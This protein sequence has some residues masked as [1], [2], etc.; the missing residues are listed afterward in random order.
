[1]PKLITSPALL[2]RGLALTLLLVLALPAGAFAHAG[3]VESQPVPGSEL[4]AGPAQ[5]SLEFTEPLNRALTEVQLRDAEDG[6]TVPAAVSFPGESEVRLIPRVRL[7]RAA[8]RIEWRTVSTVDGHALEGSFGFGVGTPAP[9]GEGSV[10]QSPLARDG[11]LRIAARAVFYAALLFF[12]G[13]LFA[14]ILLGSPLE[15]ARWLF[16]PAVAAGLSAA[17]R[18]RGHLVEAAW[19]R[20]VDAGW[21]AAGA[22]ALVATV[23]AIDA[24]GGFSLDGMREFLLTN[25]AG[26]GR[27]AMV[28][29]VALA[30]AMAPRLRVGAFLSLIVAF[31]AIAISGHA[32]SAEL[33]GPA[34]LT[35]WI[36]LLAAAVWV[37][38]IAQIAWAWLPLVRRVGQDARREAIRRVL[39]RFGRLALPAFAVVVLSGL[40]NALIELGGPEAL[41]ETSYGRVLAVKIALVG[42]IAAASYGHALRLRPRLLAMNPRLERRH[43]RLLSAEPLLGV[44]V[45]AAAAALVAFP[46]PP[47]QLG[48]GDEAEAAACDPCPLPAAANDELA[49]ADHA[50]SY[51]LATY[52]RRES[53]EL[54]G[55]VRVLDSQGRPSEPELSVDGAELERCG[56]GCGRFALPGSTNAVTIAVEEEGREFRATVP[57]RW[58][59]GADARARRLLVRSEATMRA[60]D[61]LR[62]DERLTSGPGAH[63]RTRYRLRAP[64]RMAYETSTGARGVV[65]GTREWLRS[66]GEPWEERRFGAGEPFRITDLLRWSPYASAVRLLAIERDRRRRV[67]EIA[68]MNSA[69]PPLW[70]RLRIELESMR[71]LS[72]RMTTPAHFMSRRYFAYDRP[73]SIRPPARGEATR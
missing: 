9:E 16:P 21:L 61:S 37:G 38:G 49:V 11:W 66:R 24:A 71:V 32:Y 7:D 28:V 72:D 59:P 22:A 45:V 33:R 20:T 5:I 60:L 41:W 65:V 54:E 56:I 58:R 12:A 35:D 67:A 73:L 34:V 26:L 2:G 48:E 44:G 27:L 6:R 17:G 39:K 29:A 13:G 3:F 53:G 64:G 55:T 23:E 70:F 62:E 69:A 25:S 15:P 36:H 8:Y 31:M 19:R 46:L 43:W 47:Q 57:A 40:T 68:T 50:G 1:M 4:Q 52:L 14:A 42:L 30:A 18:E 51:M 10:Q 63:V